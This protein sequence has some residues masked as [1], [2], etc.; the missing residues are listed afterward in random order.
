M[1]TQGCL[2]KKIQ[3]NVKLGRN[4]AALDNFTFF[5]FGSL[6]LGSLVLKQKHET[7]FCLVW[8]WG[9][10][11]ED[12]GPCNLF[13]LPLV[14]VDETELNV[15][16]TKH[17]KPYWLKTSTMS[18]LLPLIIPNY[19]AKLFWIKE[20]TLTGNR[21]RSKMVNN[22]KD[23]N[24]SNSTHIRTYIWCCS[25]EWP[26]Y[27]TCARFQSKCKCLINRLPCFLLESPS[28]RT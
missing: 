26:R 6:L 3:K 9:W 17:S 22:C 16:R 25:H 18:S 1:Y 28:S 10:Y 27:S 21:Q 19:G 24:F 15:W 4:K 11:E 8:Q 14:S 23:G 5:G 20:T 13:P 12:Q 7:N 2:H